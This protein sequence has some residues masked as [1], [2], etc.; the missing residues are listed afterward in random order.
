MKRFAFACLMASCFCSMHA[1]DSPLSPCI[2]LFMQTQNSA[3]ITNTFRAQSEY[4]FMWNMNTEYVS[5]QNN[6]NGWFDSQFSITGNTSGYLYGWDWNLDCSPTPQIQ[7]G[8]Y[9]IS[10]LTSGKS[11]SFDIDYRGCY[12]EPGDVVILYDYQADQFKRNG[13]SI[14]GTLITPPNLGSSTSCLPIPMVAQNSFGRGTIKTDGS[15]RTA[16]YSASWFVTSTHS[17]EAVTPQT[18]SGLVYS[19]SSWSDGG[20]IA[21]N[22]T[23]GLTQGAT[24]YTAT[25]AL[26]KPVKVSNVTVGGNVGSPVTLN[27]TV[28]VNANV[29]YYIYRKVKRDGVMGSETYVGTCS[30]ATTT[31]Q[32]PDYDVARSSSD[33]LFYDVRAHHIPSGTFADSWWASSIYGTP[34]DKF[35]DK[36]QQPHSNT[37]DE[38]LAATPNPF[39]PSSRIQFS[40]GSPGYVDVT[41]F[42][43]LGRVVNEL[44]HGYKSGGTYSLDWN[45]SASSGIQVSS[46]TFIVRCTITNDEGTV[47]SLRSIRTV[48]IR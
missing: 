25:F 39:N 41:V 23:I 8:R 7:R 34:S 47:R 18:D 3:G 5:N 11:A 20:N 6:P 15:S 42:D 37:A 26:E 35:N 9:H 4:S 10:V 12:D 43:V 48:L 38:W 24:S 1:Q 40:I 45:P 46:G 27:W 22:V 33:L 36:E 44:Y 13:T 31:F 2:E 28:H 29:N 32:D 21:H 14:N 17:I 16:P 19:F 30:H